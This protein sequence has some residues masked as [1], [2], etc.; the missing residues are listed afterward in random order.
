MDAAQRQ[1]TP[2]GCVCHVLNRANGRMRLFLNE[3]GFDAF[4]AFEGK[5]V[6]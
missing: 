6:V 5:S 4:N 1:S 2:A 3:A